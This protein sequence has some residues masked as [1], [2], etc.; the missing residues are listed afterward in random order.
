MKTMTRRP[1]FLALLAAALVGTACSTDKETDATTATPV[2]Q[3][4]GPGN[5]AVA[6]SDTLRS[7]PAISGTLIADR[8]ARIR[9]EMMQVIART[10]W[11]AADPARAAMPETER[12]SAFIAFLR[13]DPR[14]YC[15]TQSSAS[16]TDYKDIV[17][18][19]F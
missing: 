6:R 17:C 15:S 18:M 11:Y 19:A 9:A 13:S 4:I 2:S 16:G 5:I 1:A 14:F 3:N 12:F 8:E 7:G 10:D